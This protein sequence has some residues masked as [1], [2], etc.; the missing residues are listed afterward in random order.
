MG[1]QKKDVH[2]NKDGADVPKLK[3]VEVILLHCYLVNNSYQQT[4]AI[5][6]TFVTNEQFGQIITISLH[7]LTMLKSTNAEFQSIELWFTDQNNR[8]LEIQH[9][10][11]I[12]LIIG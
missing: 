3:S 12:T 11:N 1:V 2:K 5:L 4:S 6:F 8:P 7:L 9:S 10:V